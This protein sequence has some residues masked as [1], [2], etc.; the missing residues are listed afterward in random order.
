MKNDFMKLLDCEDSGE[1]NEYVGVKIDKKDN[2]VKLTQPVLIQSLEDEFEIPKDT[3]K[4]LPAPLGK[5][6]LSDGERLSPK[7]EKIYQ[8][9]VGKLLFLMRY[10]RPDILNV[11]RELSKW[12]T[13]GSIIRRYCNK[14]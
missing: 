7:D 4:H 5:D 8:S 9:G 1:L 10:S 13:E 2:A 14:L 12:M 11:V 3:P 6:L